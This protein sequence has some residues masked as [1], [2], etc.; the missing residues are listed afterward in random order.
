LTGV[1]D[2]SGAPAERPVVASYCVTFLKPEMLHIYRQ[3]TAL[4]RFRPIVIAQKREE[5]ER[6]PFAPIEVVGK[7]GTHFLR[8]FWFKQIRKAPWQISNSELGKLL[9]I[10]DRRNAQLLHIYFGHIAVHLLPLI[11]KWPR[12]TVVS[13]HGADVMVDMDKPAHRAAT[14]RMLRAV[15]LVLVRSRSL[16]DAVIRI[17]CPE[18]KIRIQR[19]GIPVAETPFVERSW[20]TD[21]QWR[22]VQAGRLIEKKGF[23]TSLRAFAEFAARYPNATF[24]IAG[25]GPLQD[26]LQVQARD[27]GITDKV[28]F[29]GFISQKELH[30][31]FYSAHIFLHPSETGADGN[32]E[33]IP[34][35]M[36]EAMASGL[37]VFATIHGGIPEAIENDRSGILVAE[38]DH[39]AL[40][41]K[42][43]EFAATPQ[44]LS[45]IGR[46][47]AKSVAEKFD[48]ATQARKLEDYYFEALASSPSSLRRGED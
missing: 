39:A 35:S 31:L 32:Q 33:G 34:N 40:A 11:L 10:L 42:L 41:A 44:R 2:R 22:F 1:T 16:R 48:Q 46:A 6:F 43:L 18:N 13:F 29:R 12:A 17:G 28:F 36:L 23:A 4:N 15:R 45:D 7:P 8:R 25:G 5:P 24:T 19:T 30:K 9:A 37:P 21:G 3:I 27:L 20:P 38:K 47:G 14:E 26:E